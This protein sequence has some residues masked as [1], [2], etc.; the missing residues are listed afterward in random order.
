MKKAAVAAILIIIALTSSCRNTA[1]GSNDVHSSPESVMQAFFEGFKHNN[2]EMILAS[3][4][5]QTRQM[6]LEQMPDNPRA[7]M[8]KWIEDKWG[9]PLSEVDVSRI[10]LSIDED[11]G[12]RKEVH[13]HY[14]GIPCKDDATVIRIDGKWYVAW[15]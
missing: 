5:P 7:E 9:L 15:F 13:A 6:M 3:I 14:N 10:T 11:Q 4:S 12:D 1:S 8:N 2:R